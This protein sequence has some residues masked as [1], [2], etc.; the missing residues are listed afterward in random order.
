[1]W[2]LVFIVT[3]LFGSLSI[4]VARADGLPTECS[5]KKIQKNVDACRSV[6]LG[7]MVPYIFKLKAYRN[8]IDYYVDKRKSKEALEIIELSSHLVPDVVDG[9]KKAPNLSYAVDGAV[10]VVVP[11]AV[12]PGAASLPLAL[13]TVERRVALVIGE[14][15]YTAVGPLPNAKSDA[16]LVSESL[17]A[18]GFTSVDELVNA[19]RAT[20]IA[21]LRA[22]SQKADQADWAMIY[23]AGHGM[24]LNGDN[25]VI[26][27]D[28]AL[29]SDRDVGDE[30]IPLT[31]L[32]ASTEGASKLKLVILDACRN[33]PFLP[34]MQR[35]ITTR[36]IGRGLSRVEPD[37][38][39]LVVF[40]AKEGTVAMDG[41][42]TNGPFASAFAQRVRQPGIE[43]SKLF[44]FV[45]QDVMAA[46]SMQQEPFVYGS[47]PPE[48]FIF[49]DGGSR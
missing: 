1:M 29:A 44:R 26:P 6:L 9:E 24:E 47:L 41:E 17:R 46:T 30:A 3:L 23:Y 18:I 32:E 7:N 11:P 33:N 36:Q 27:V 28:A 14:S 22:F 37:H 4:P 20:L 43:I 21:G 2:K 48:D 10:A 19:D 34:K 38:A 15:T 31:R 5:P 16:H 13:R 25:Y 8:L 49:F 40:A 45:R 12:Q 42:G 39:T 35:A